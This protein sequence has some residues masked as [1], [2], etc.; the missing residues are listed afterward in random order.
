MFVGRNSLL[1]LK[2]QRLHLTVVN[3]VNTA[4][5]ID[6]LFQE[7]VLRAQDMRTLQLQKDDPQQQCRDLLA[8]LHTSE[9]PLAFVHLYRAIK[10]KPHLQWLTEEI[11]EY[12]TGKE[13]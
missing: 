13:L 12:S 3:S 10:E 6:F 8:L 4:N 2:F 1:K 11:D 9:N 5:V 7:G